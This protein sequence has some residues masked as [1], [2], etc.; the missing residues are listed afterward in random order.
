MQTKS[1][2]EEVRPTLET[3]KSTDLQRIN[4]FRWQSTASLCLFIGR[5]SDVIVSRF[6]LGLPNL[7]I[8]Q[9]MHNGTSRSGF[10]E[11]CH[12]ILKFLLQAK[13]QK[14]AGQTAIARRYNHTT[15]EVV[16]IGCTG[17]FTE[18]AHSIILRYR[19]HALGCGGGTSAAMFARIL[20]FS[21]I[22]EER[23]GQPPRPR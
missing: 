2:I 11:I 9:Q 7:Y 13:V 5:P 1:R 15:V 10:F 8:L 3:G 16:G 4:K 17:A 23:I 19:M 21:Y 18:R 20:T 22:H 12:E 14:T 6:V